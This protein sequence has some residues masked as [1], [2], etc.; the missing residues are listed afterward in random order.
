VFHINVGGSPAACLA[1]GDDMLAKSRFAGRL[2][3]IDLGDAGFG[4]AANSERH[5]QREGAGGNCFHLHLVSFAEA[6]DAAFA[7]FFDNI[8]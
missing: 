1:F 8:V 2:G 6:H 3:T 5:I 4:D 7:V